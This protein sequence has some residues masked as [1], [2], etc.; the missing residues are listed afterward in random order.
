MD[1]KKLML[2]CDLA[3]V[4]IEKVQ[5]L[6][7]TAI[8]SQKYDGICAVQ[9][10]KGLMTRSGKKLAN[11]HLDYIF[12]DL[13]VGVTGEFAYSDV[14]DE[15]AFKKA[16][17]LCNTKKISLER[18][19][20][21]LQGFKF[22]IFNY[23]EGW[24]IETYGDIPYQSRMNQIR[25]MVRDLEYTQVV[26]HFNLD[27]TDAESIGNASKGEGIIVTFKESPYFPGRCGKT[28]PYSLK[29][30]KLETCESTIIGYEQE[31]YGTNLKTIPQELQGKPKNKVGKLLLHNDRFGE[32]VVGTGLTDVEKTD[33]F[34]NFEDYRGKS[35]SIS[36]MP[37]KKGLPRMPRY[38]GIREDL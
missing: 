4:N 12:K 32:H 6:N 38:L 5:S 24:D 14:E 17:T 2:S 27:I 23:V 8:Y 13:P 10:S 34:L 37:V 3:K 19:I 16:T 29:V 25:D 9:T 18:T 30:K 15:D 20:D 1:Y 22:Y 26:E 35:C 33:I 31:F 36:F 21:L 7:M 11:K 28:T